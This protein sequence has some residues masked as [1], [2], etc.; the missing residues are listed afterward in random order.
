MGSTIMSLFVLAMT[1]IMGSIAV[2]SCGKLQSSTSVILALCTGVLMFTGLAMAIGE[3]LNRCVIEGCT[4]AAEIVGRQ[5]TRA[6]FVSLF[7]PIV[8]GILG[9][10]AVRSNARQSAS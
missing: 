2:A 9:V 1:V 4:P 5:Y 8:V 3:P 7:A 10:L 6:L